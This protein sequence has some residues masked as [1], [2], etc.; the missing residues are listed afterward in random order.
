MDFE[1]LLN[2]QS[3]TDV[4]RKGKYILVS[5]ESDRVWVIHLGMTGKL[6]YWRACRPREKHAHIIVNFKSGGG[7]VFHDPRRFGLAVVLPLRDLD[8]WSPLGRLGVDPLSEAIN[9]PHFRSL[10][11]GSKRKV[12]DLL[13]DQTVLAGLGNI[14]ANEALFQAGLR[15]SRRARTVTIREAERLARAIPQILAQA[16][17]WR[18]TSFSDYRDGNDRKGEFQSRLAVYNRDGEPCRV[19]S[20][21][22][23]R[24]RMGNRGA[25]FCPTCQR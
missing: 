20:R 9:G 6:V 13:L 15:P 18:G 21:T 12:R 17:R 11:R 7:I 24:M 25:Y 1:N 5:L 4:R 14:Y 19:C 3:I 16:I 22:I 10:M 2:G 8:R 23:K